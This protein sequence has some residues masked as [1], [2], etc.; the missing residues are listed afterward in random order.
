MVYADTWQKKGNVD[1][2]EMKEGYENPR[3]SSPNLVVKMPRSKSLK[4][5]SLLPHPHRRVSASHAQAITHASQ[6][7]PSCKNVIAGRYVG[8]GAANVRGSPF[9]AHT[10]VCRRLERVELGESARAA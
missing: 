5:R 4:F 6:L 10:V 3:T 1:W 9:E 8:A 7:R 2:S